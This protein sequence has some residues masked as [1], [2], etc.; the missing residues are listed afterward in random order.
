MSTTK[1]KVI[2]LDDDKIM[3]QFIQ[4][5]A[6]ATGLTDALE[7]I[8]VYTVPDAEAVFNKDPSAVFAV[9]IDGTLADHKLKTTLDFVGWLNQ[10]FYGPIIAMSS[11]SESRKRQ[12]SAGCT[13]DNG[14]DSKTDVC[15]LIKRLYEESIRD[16]SDF[17]S[18][19]DD[20]RGSTHN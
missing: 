3:H 4:N 9:A 20:P 14:T 12:M 13:H 18:H 15:R 5:M 11:S 6:R 2:V 10:R 17:D 7:V 19:D 16:T 1:G 8:S